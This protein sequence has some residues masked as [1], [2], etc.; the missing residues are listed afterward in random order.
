MF[1]RRIFTHLYLCAVF[2]LY[3]E[4][5]PIKDQINYIKVI[6]LNERNQRFHIFLFTQ[7]IPKPKTIYLSSFSK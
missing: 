6:I 4:G 1:D 7:K 2:M 3:I 5:K